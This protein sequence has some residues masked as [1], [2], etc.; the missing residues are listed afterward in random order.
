MALKE[1]KLDT[2][3]L[4]YL[5]T[6]CG[7]AP[8]E[9]AIEEA[10]EALVLRDPNHSM[11]INNRPMYQAQKD[12]RLLCEE[13][14]LLQM[15]FRQL[16][17]KLNIP[18]DGETELI[19]RINSLEK[20]ML[21]YV[22]AHIERSGHGDARQW[23][24]LRGADRKP[25][26]HTALR[27]MREI[28]AGLKH[29]DDMDAAASTAPDRRD[30]II[31]V[32]KSTRKELSQQ[33]IVKRMAKLLGLRPEDKRTA[34]GVRDGFAQ[35][36][37]A[38]IILCREGDGDRFYRIKR[39]ARKKKTLTKK[40]VLAKTEQTPGDKTSL[41]RNAVMEVFKNWQTKCTAE[42]V[43]LD[44]EDRT[45][46]NTEDQRDRSSIHRILREL[47]NDGVLQRTSQKGEVIAANGATRIVKL[48]VYQKKTKQVDRA[49]EKAA[50]KLLEMPAPVVKN[51]THA[52]A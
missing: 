46:L 52:H 36:A 45:G 37:A 17:E 35:L 25:V 1:L 29:C 4:Q 48:Y 42:E 20:R 23:A 51:G 5:V 39:D 47:V 49:V 50:E 44:I 18:A 43:I 16:M 14:E 13:L 26:F 7:I 32:L 24:V 12:D 27:T 41:R 28:E 10:K 31:K 33:E 11:L 2:T 15:C 21:I 6:V 40:P 9:K 22:A 8:L 38:G 34:R 30:A 19:A 3:N